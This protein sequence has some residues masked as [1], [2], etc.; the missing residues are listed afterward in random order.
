MILSGRPPINIKQEKE[1]QKDELLPREN[2]QQE[3]L[4]E[5]TPKD[6]DEC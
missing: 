4:N 2:T 3:E 6:D 5:R 1:R